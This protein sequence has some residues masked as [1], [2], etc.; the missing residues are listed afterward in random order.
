MFPGSTIDQESLHA[1]ESEKARL[2]GEETYSFT[3][4]FINYKSFPRFR[5]NSQ[6]I[7]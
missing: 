4:C 6:P 2:T 5:L 1:I 7:D 3:I